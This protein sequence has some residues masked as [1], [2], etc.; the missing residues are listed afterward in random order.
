MAKKVQRAKQRQKQKHPRAAR[1]N[2]LHPFDKIETR[3][4]WPSRFAFEGAREITIGALR[5]GG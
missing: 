2:L 3:G 1:S 4:P 5:M